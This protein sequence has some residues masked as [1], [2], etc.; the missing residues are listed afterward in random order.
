MPRATSPYPPETTS[1]HLFGAAPNLTEG[2]EIFGSLLLADDVVE[3]PL[4]FRIRRLK[5]R[6]LGA[7][8][9]E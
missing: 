2:C 3:E 4:E 6:R 9:D 7:T 1:V 5:E 8:L